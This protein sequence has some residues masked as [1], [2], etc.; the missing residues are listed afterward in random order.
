MSEI[1]KFFTEPVVRNIHPEVID[2]FITVRLGRP[3]T[4]T[5]PPPVAVRPSFS[6]APF[7]GL[8]STRKSNATGRTA[9]GRQFVGRAATGVR[10]LCKYTD[11][12]TAAAFFNVLFS[13]TRRSIIELLKSHLS[14]YCPKSIEP[15]TAT[16]DHG[17]SLFCSFY[18]FH[19]CLYHNTAL[20][21]NLYLYK[22]T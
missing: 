20:F 7:N 3:R 17:P 2:G 1:S 14:G 11:G 6:R 12:R 15:S 8:F 5:S 19:S 18:P 10:K 16:N 13:Y 22:R 4:I 9:G 21:I